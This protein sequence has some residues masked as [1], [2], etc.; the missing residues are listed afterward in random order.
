[1]R[2]TG[3]LADRDSWV[4]YGVCPIEKAMKVVGSRN[5]MLT[6]REAFYGTTRFDDFAHRV[7]MSSA[8]TAA[9]LKALVGAGLLEKR[10]YREEGS[11]ERHEYVLTPAGEGLMPIV[12]GLFAW[13]MEHCDSPPPLSL[14]HAECGSPLTAQLVCGDDHEVAPDDVELRVRRTRARSGAG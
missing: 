8:T 13:G 10:A 9:N 11:R 2:L 3:V 1:M 4:T 7:G 6:L 5:A 14:R 12:F